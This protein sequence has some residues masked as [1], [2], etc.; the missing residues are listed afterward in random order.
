MFLEIQN[1]PLGYY[2]MMDIGDGTSAQ[3]SLSM[4]PHDFIIERV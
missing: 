1:N 4:V 2:D 3:N